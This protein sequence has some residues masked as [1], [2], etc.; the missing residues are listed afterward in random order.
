MMKKYQLWFLGFLS[1]SCLVLASNEHS[2]QAV[3]QEQRH[4]A[5]Q[6]SYRAISLVDVAE[7]LCQVICDIAQDNPPAIG[8][9]F[10]DVK[11][12]QNDVHMIFVLHAACGSLNVTP[13]PFV[14]H[15]YQRCCLRDDERARVVALCKKSLDSAIRSKVQFFGCSEK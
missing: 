7:K 3:F 5:H 12:S 9:K 10:D 4:K 6:D 15:E 1:I 2:M 13:C 14:C 11:N 8:V